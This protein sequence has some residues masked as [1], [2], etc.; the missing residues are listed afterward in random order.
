MNQPALFNLVMPVPVGIILP[1]PFMLQYLPTYVLITFRNSFKIRAEAF[2]LA[3]IFTN[4]GKNGLAK[5]M[6]SRT[7]TVIYHIQQT[8]GTMIIRYRYL[9]TGFPTSTCIQ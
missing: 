6:H 4:T 5:E 3:H 7:A 8:F 1:I 9:G 2:N